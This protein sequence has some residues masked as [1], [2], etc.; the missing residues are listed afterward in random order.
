[1]AELWSERAIFGFN[2]KELG[3]KLANFE[4]KTAELGL[5]NATS[6]FKKLKLG[7][8]MPVFL[9]SNI[10][11]LESKMGISVSIMIKVGS[12]MAL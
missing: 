1:M 11:N 8:Q 2:L 6:G 5:L 9:G 10:V 12:K 7:S 4:S 3:S